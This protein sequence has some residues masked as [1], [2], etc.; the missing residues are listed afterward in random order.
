MRDAGALALGLEG[1][2]KQNLVNKE[3][4]FIDAGKVQQLLT[5]FKKY[6]VGGDGSVEL[7]AKGE[8]R[9]ARLCKYLKQFDNCINYDQ[10]IELGLPIGSGEAVELEKIRRRCRSEVAQSNCYQRFQEMGLEYGPCFRGI[11]QLW[12]G[13]GEALGRIAIPTA[14]KTQLQ[15]Y[16]LHPAILD[17]C[18]QVLLGAVSG[19]RAYLPVHIERVRLYRSPGFDLWSYGRIVEQSDARIKGDIQLLDE[20]GNVVAEIQGLRCQSLGDVQDSS[21]E[22]QGNLLY[23]EQWELKVR[24]GQKLA[25]L[26]GNYL[27]SPQQIADS[28]QPEVRRL[29]EQLGRQHYYEVVEPQLEILSVAYVLKALEGLGWQ[30]QLQQR[31]AADPLAEQLGVISQ[32]RKLLGRMLE[33]LQGEGV[34]TQVDDQWQVCQIPEVKQPLSIWQACLAKYPAYTAELMLLGRCGDQLAE[35]LRG[36]VDPLELIFP[37]GSLTASEHLYQDS[38]SFRIYNQLVKSSIARALENLPKGQKVRILEIGA[39]TGGMTSY[40]L[41]LLPAKQTEYVFTDVTRQFTAAAEQKFQDY[42]FI[43]YGILDLEVDPVSQGFE[44]HSFD[45]ILAADVLHAT[46]DLRH[47]LENIKH[48][49]ASEGL[50]VL[51]ELTSAPRWFDLVLG[52][53]EDWRL[54]KDWDLRASN[55]PLSAQNW[56]DLL[57]EAGFAQIA[58][59]SD[60]EATSESLHTVVLAQGPDVELET[61]PPLPV[62]PQQSKPGSWLIFADRLGVGQQLAERLTECWEIPILISP[63]EAYQCLDP[64]H[65]QLPL[66]QPQDLQRLL[67][68]VSAHQPPCRGVVHLWSLDITPAEETTVASL[69]EA[70]KQG[71]I[72]VLNLVQAL[73]E[74]SLSPRLV[75]VTQ[76]AQA[77]G[78]SAKSV[79]VAQSPLWGLGRVI[80]NEHPALN[81]T[82]IDLSPVITPEEI[83]SLFNGLWS[84]DQED[85]VA[86]R[87][88]VRHVRRLTPVSPGE[89][90]KAG[91][92]SV[93]DAPE[94]F[95]LE[96]LTPGV[97]DSLTLRDCT[98]Q[99][100]GP[101]EVEI[102]VY[103][104]GLNFKDVAKAMNL[105]DEVNLEGN[106]TGRSL[107]FDCSG[108]ITAIGL[109]VTGFEIGEEVIALAPHNFGS[110]TITDANLVVPKPADLSFEAAATIPLVFLT[111]YH[112][113]H[114]WG[115]MDRGDRVLIHAGAGGVGLAA[116]QLAQRAGAEIFA[117]AGSP[118]KREFLRSLG[119]KYVMD[120][121]SLEFAEQVMEYTEGQGVDLVLNSLAGAAIPKSL[122]ILGAYG[123]FLEIGKRDIDSNSKL[124]LR[125]FQKNLSFFAIDPDRLMGDRPE[126]AGKQLRELVQFFA[127]GTLHPL[128]HRVFPI[129]KARTAFRYMAS[130]KHVGKVVVSL[131]DPDVAVTSEAIEGS[132]TF[133]PDGTYLITGGLGGF[134]LT[135]AQWLIERGAKQLVLISRS[136][137]STVPEK[138][139]AARQAV[140]TLESKGAEVVVAKADVTQEQQVAGVLADIRQSMPPLRGI[141]H[142]AVIYDDAL[143]VQLNQERFEKVMAPKVMGAWNLHTQTS[144][145]PLDF[146]ILFSSMTTTLGNPGQGNYVAAN[147]FMDILAQHRR[148]ALGLPGLRV[149]WGAIGGVGYVAQNQEVGEHLQRIGADIVPSQEALK[150]LG[151]LLR[152]EAVQT[153]VGRID[154]QRWAGVHAAAKLLRY[155]HVMANS[156]EADEGSSEGEN[157]G[158]K[159][160]EAPAAEGLEILGSFLGEQLAKVLGT[161]PSKLNAEQSLSNLGLDSLM[162]AEMSNRIKSKLGISITTMKLIGGASIASLA[163][164]LLQ[165]ITGTG[166]RASAAESE[167]IVRLKPHRDARLRL[168]CFPYNAGAV[169]AFHPWS[170]LLSSDLELCAVNYP[171][172][173]DFSGEPFEQ[174]DGLLPALAAAMLP[175][176][177][178]PFV[179]YGHS[180]GALIAFE[181]AR[182]LRRAHGLNPERLF[183][184]ANY[185]P[186]LPNPYPPFPQVSDDELK[187]ATS[188]TDLP[189][190]IWEKIKLVLPE[191]VLESIR[192][193]A[194]YMRS[195]MP[196]VKAGRLLMDNYT[197]SESEPLDCPMSVFGGKQDPVITED[198]LLAW[199]EQTSSTFKLQMFPGHHLFL[200]EDEKLL[201]QTISQEL[202]PL[203]SSSQE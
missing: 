143:L 29:R 64:Q 51:V 200:H 192:E 174:L 145:A 126:L 156:R 177:D 63:G 160:Q 93:G 189:K 184:A 88:A 190:S 154:W 122:S 163:T 166:P 131:Q 62:S 66:G 40:V 36:E 203:L 37:K 201:L 48:L 33:M 150:M 144:N 82:K 130:A 115:R 193:N 97:L 106:F 135:T 168:F 20:A 42:P 183:L 76:A 103:A 197:Y 57:A 70:G 39:G 46:R 49:L 161:S 139:E 165:E 50:L 83:Q 158:N 13:T 172:T 105:L 129:S 80:N 2:K 61:Q 202:M 27:P 124:G 152:Q 178:K 187:Q 4:E 91:K 186:D 59:L 155:S 132:V 84:D 69:S 101:G 140:K 157:L 30:P 199:R 55:P 77:I 108:I 169:G 78:E 11:E 92:Q 171:G 8:E 95:R 6:L 53:L 25:R 87:G 120:S 89:I 162:A 44:A 146:F 3:L 114:Y 191:S 60:T 147:G 111:A 15:D 123:R 68:A 81:C 73:A 1:S 104:T 94:A 67:E 167:W 56:G 116:I 110:Y 176:L 198:K 22:Q 127:D 164:E 181:L 195:V 173:V 14:I 7:T 159:L 119:V 185:A 47:T 43:Q 74:R 196:H 113:L 194:E 72:S 9:L 142:A 118:E 19:K 16:Q 5:N 182:Y 100:P 170:S 90:G 180:L 34:L 31:F 41:P 121:R 10:F 99:E 112:A 136:G 117:T 28:L 96:I 24:P 134:G 65:F 18:F 58:G 137:P 26:P 188:I 38:P 35:V 71:C 125:P 179:F 148:Q 175:E 32:H 75:L 86:L 128:P 107:G 138:S 54:F 98:R 12:T 102:Q 133:R 17:A 45:L 153:A 151:V 23:E 109:G 52:M 21:S 85:E 149:N 79:S 141:I